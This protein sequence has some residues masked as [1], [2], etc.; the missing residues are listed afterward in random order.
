MKR[1][2]RGIIFIFLGLLMSFTAARFSAAYE[3]QEAIAGEN[4]EI[5]LQELRQEMKSAEPEIKIPAPTPAPTLP[6][7]EPES[8]PTEPEVV[9]M[10]QTTLN[11]YA[12]VGILQVPAVG[13]ELPILDSWNYDLLK[14]SPCRYSGTA[15]GGN[16]ILLAHNYDRHF[17]PFKQLV[18]GDTVTFLSVDGTRYQY[19][20][21]ATEILQKTEL[22][23]LTSSGHDLTL[24]TCTKGG[25]SR[26][27][28]RCDKLPTI[29]EQI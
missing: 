14:I 22:E 25:Y 9:E 24:F 27:V 8:P 4:A 7:E 5:L 29:L 16:L 28:V 19:A 21:T 15:A 12:L 10:P 23:R 11:G 13:L 18:P 3:Q 6:S 17:G 1:K 26:V 2:T 20:V